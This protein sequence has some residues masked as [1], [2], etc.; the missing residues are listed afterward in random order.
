M[1]PT[2]KKSAAIKKEMLILQNVLGK[3]LDSAE[4]LQVAL[5]CAT[6]RVVVKR[7]RLAGNICEKEPNFS[8][9]GKNSRFDIYLV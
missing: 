7:P 4:L 8:L 3:E 5:T 2:R 9:T 6:Q 1:F